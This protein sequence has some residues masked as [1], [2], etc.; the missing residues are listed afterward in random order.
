MTIFLLLSIVLAVSFFFTGVEAAILSLSPSRIRHYSRQ[1]EPSAVR[2]ERLLDNPGRLLIT[3]VLTVNAC[4]GIA[5]ALLVNLATKYLGASGYAAAAL[6][7]LPIWLFVLGVLPKGLF[8]RMPYRLLAAC[9]K[10]L[11]WWVRL[12]SPLTR[13]FERAA[14]PLLRAGAARGGSPFASR[15]ELRFFT[16]AS[17][18]AGNLSS[19]ERDFLLSVLDFRSLEAKD[20]MTPWDR[21]IT[22]DADAPLNEALDRARERN[23]DRMPAVD[24]AGR[25]IG[26]ILTLDMLLDP[27]DNARARDYLRQLVSVQARDPAHKVLRQL[28][29]ARLKLALVEDPPG[30]PAGVVFSEDLMARLFANPSPPDKAPGR[31]RKPEGTGGVSRPV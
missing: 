29:A 3:I 12:L 18:R 8:R 2:L 24:D 10:P 7:A 15:E 11:E 31:R 20:V 26:L 28:R 21:V 14:G 1:N 19:A 6:A 27:R 16:E 4:N 5:L 9:V 13:V 25:V 23:L 30:T 22:V 17:A